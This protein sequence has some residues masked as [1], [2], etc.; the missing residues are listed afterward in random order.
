[1]GQAAA[2]DAELRRTGR[3]HA[4]GHVAAAEAPGGGEACQLLWEEALLGVGPTP[5]KVESRRF[6]Y[7]SAGFLRKECQNTVIQLG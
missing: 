3:L 1:M 2:R 7:L 6:Q 4:A 5:D